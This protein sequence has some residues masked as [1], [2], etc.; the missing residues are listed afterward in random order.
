MHPNL[1]MHLNP[2]IQ[3]QGGITPI[4]AFAFAPLL[5]YFGDKVWSLV[6]LS[7]RLSSPYIRHTFDIKIIFSSVSKQSSSALS[8]APSSP[9]ELFPSSPSTGVCSRRFLEILHTHEYVVHSSLIQHNCNFDIVV[10]QPVTQAAE[11]I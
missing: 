10:T 5:G 2:E 3:I 9:A 1:E 11:I 6:L 7:L 8:W 4:A